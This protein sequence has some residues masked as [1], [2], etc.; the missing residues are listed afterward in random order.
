MN[1]QVEVVNGIPSPPA[2]TQNVKLVALK[3]CSNS[4]LRGPKRLRKW[5]VFSFPLSWQTFTQLRS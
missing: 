1:G 2:T 5:K 4:H 3:V